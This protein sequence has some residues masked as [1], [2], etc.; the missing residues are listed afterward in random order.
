MPE[1]GRPT[2]RA[3]GGRRAPQLTNT[4]TTQPS[5]RR[6]PSASRQASRL[7]QVFD[8][9]LLDA[10][11]ARAPFEGRGAHRSALSPLSRVSG[12]CRRAS[13]A[14]SKQRAASWLRRPRDGLAPRLPEVRDGL[15]PGFAPERVVGEPLDVLGEPVGIQRARWPS[16]MPAWSAPPPVLEQAP[17]GHLVGERVLEGVLEIGK[18]LRLVQELRRLEAGQ[19][20][21]QLRLAAARRSPASSA[22]RARPSRSPRRSGGALVLRRQPIDAGGQHGLHRRGHLD[23]SAAGRASR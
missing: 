17:V 18:R 5:R 22:T 12:R 1:H 23:A 15:V 21:A 8:D 9:R 16:T 7:G 19:A 13:S 2:R 10:R 11:A 20:R 4:P 6:S 3:R 14:C